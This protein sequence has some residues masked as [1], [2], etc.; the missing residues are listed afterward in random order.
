ML[1]I[2]TH[3]AFQNTDRIVKIGLFYFYTLKTAIKCLIFFKM[4][5]IFFDSSGTY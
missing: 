3:D 2:F 1:C 4:L 5:G